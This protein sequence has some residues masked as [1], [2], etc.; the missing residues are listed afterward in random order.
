MPVLLLWGADDALIP[1][2]KAQDFQRA[3]PQAELVVLPQL[4]HLL[5]EEQ[6]QSS[7]QPLLEFLQR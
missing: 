6:P 5:Q 1:V 7:V 4:G 3:M 2:R